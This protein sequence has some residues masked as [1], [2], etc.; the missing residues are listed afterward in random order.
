M[1][2]R[3][4]WKGVLQLGELEVP[5]KLYAAVEDRKVR[6]RLLHARDRERVHQHMVD[7]ETG[8]EV[9]AEEVRKGYEAEPGVFVVLRDEELAELEPAPSRQIE[10]TRFV[11]P[12]KINHQWYLRP[13]YLGPDDSDE[14]YFALAAALREA[15]REG[16]ARWTMRK[17]RYLGALRPEGE[18]L[19]LITLRH[20][21]EVVSASELEP[22]AGRALD[23]HELAMAE[24]LV[25]ALAAPFDPTQYADAYRERVLELVRTKA[26]GGTVE[27]KR[28]ERK[29][30]SGSLVDALAASLASARQRKGEGRAHG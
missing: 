26:R 25:G 11:A 7:A 21:S 23:R 24:Q 1:A 12:E 30:P 16:V 5:V 13:Y 4:I 15:G 17:Q 27:P 29:E 19:M 18:H 22:P 8:D 2:A 9:P 3:A 6:F 10:I 20:A 14:D 28:F